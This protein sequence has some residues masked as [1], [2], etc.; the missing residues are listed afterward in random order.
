MYLCDMKKIRKPKYSSYVVDLEPFA[1][2]LWVTIQQ[3]NQSQGYTKD[4]I[5]WT[6][7]REVRFWTDGKAS[8]I[9]KTIAD[10]F[11]NKYPNENPFDIRYD[12]RK[13][14]GMITL[15]KLKQSCFMLEHTTPV[16]EFIINLVNSKSLEDVKN[17]MKNYSGVCILTRE[18]D[19][20][21]NKNGFRK[22]RNGAWKM[23]YDKCG[24]DVMTEK[25]FMDYK[26]NL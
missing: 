2:I 3:Y 25:E 26:N 20:C 18:E 19:N 16:G 7:D 4:R 21:L 12:N 5:K 17:N 10:I 15:D 11:I 24:I 9:S 13:K 1:E 14:Y 8:Y 6:I 22:K 23:A